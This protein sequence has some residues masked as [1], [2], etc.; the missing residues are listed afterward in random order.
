MGSPRAKLLGLKL[1]QHQGRKGRNE[2]HPDVRRDDHRATASRQHTPRC[3]RVQAERQPA[4]DQN[5]HRL[6][7]KAKISPSGR[8]SKSLGIPG[9]TCLI[10]AVGCDLWQRPRRR[11]RGNGGDGGPERKVE[12]GDTGTRAALH[13]GSSPFPPCVPPC[14]GVSV[15][16]FSPILRRLRNRSTT[17]NIRPASY[18]AAPVP[19][20]RLARDARS[21]NGPVMAVVTSAMITSIVNISGERMP[22]S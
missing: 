11:R 12:H 6:A 4:T 3:L 2:S 7:A 1:E 22:R 18:L 20:R 13:V 19:A 5:V 21:T 10:V 16:I 14:P 9:G 8:S 15:S 17:Q